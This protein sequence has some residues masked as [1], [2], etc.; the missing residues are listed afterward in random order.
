M[1]ILKQF[2]STNE[3]NS[4]ASDV[5][6]QLHLHRC[7]HH[8]PAR[9]PRAGKPQ[10]TRT[11][12]GDVRPFLPLNIIKPSK[13]Q[14]FIIQPKKWI[15]LVQFFESQMTTISQPP[16]ENPS[17]GFS[18]LSGTWTPGTRRLVLLFFGGLD[19]PNKMVKGCWTVVCFY[20]ALYDLVLDMFDLSLLVLMLL[21]FWVHWVLGGFFGAN[22]HSGCLSMRSAID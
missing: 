10:K 14:W 2:P 8:R 3:L 4:Q 6:S 5:L 19:A 16:G 18:W 22:R 15:E 1:L 13:F 9:R 21:F 20:V 11:T 17:R 12:R 7:L